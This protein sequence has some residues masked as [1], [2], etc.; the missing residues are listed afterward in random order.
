M[1]KIHK[2]SALR[3]ESWRTVPGT[4]GLYWWYFPESA[5][6]DFRIKEL[7]D[8]TQVKFKQSADGKVCLYHGM[9]NNLAQRVKWHA[10]QKLTQEALGSGFLSTFRLTLLSLSNF[11]YFAGETEID[12]FFDSLSIEWTVV[13]SREVALEMEQSNFRGDFAFP[14]N[15]QGNKIPELSLYVK[16]L[17]ATR[18]AYR[19][20]FLGT[21]PNSSKVKP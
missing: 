2:L 10:A 13:A 16:H 6:T 3:R 21:V 20:N 18:R 14:L 5:L 1:E 19:H 9:A 17:K 8:L 12:N 11:D 15:I 4:P 7:V